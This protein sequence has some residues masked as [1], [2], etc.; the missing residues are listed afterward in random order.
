MRTLMMLV[1][2]AFIAFPA[3]AA[4]QGPGSDQVG[5]FKGP[6]STPEISTVQQIANL[7]D[8]ARVTLTGNIVEKITG[9]RDKYTF[10]DDTGTIR[11]EIDKKH[12]RGQEVTPETKV[13]ISGKVDKD[14][15]K[16]TELDVKWLEIVK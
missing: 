16:P 8:D 10:R 6:G 9:T 4:F 12:F 3:Y 15:G 1:L 13:R 11:V 14:F 5:G 2:A 7:P